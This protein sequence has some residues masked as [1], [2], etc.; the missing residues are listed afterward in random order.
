MAPATAAL[1]SFTRFS[2]DGTGS[3]VTTGARGFGPSVARSFKL[4]ALPISRMPPPGFVSLMFPSLILLDATPP[5]RASMVEPRDNVAM[6][7]GSESPERP[8]RWHTGYEHFPDGF[9]DRSD[10]TDDGFF[11]LQPRLVTHIDEGAIA[12]VGR[13]YER[14]GI[15][16]RVLD[17]MGSWISHFSTPPK[18]LTVLGMNAEELDANPAATST[19]VQDLNINPELPFATDT[20]DDA[21]CCVSVD[22][23]AQ[24]LEVFE[25]LSRV[26]RPGG[27]FV[28]TFSNRCFPTKAIR[29][30]HVTDDTGHAE[31]I[32]QYF[33]QAGSWSAGPTTEVL[34][35]PGFGGDPLYAVWAIAGAP[36]A[37]LEQ[38]FRRIG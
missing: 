28:C 1:T 31:I 16:G 14:M 2:S 5:G 3:G 6:E 32:S 11:Y 34:V 22:Y 23:L 21:V 24:P 19:V 12:A 13:L 26:L 7:T 25:E 33:R 27:R 18:D 17:L 20:F 38:T 36:G 29:G 10:E 15:D 35:P 30:W 37:I 4:E 9:F 8:V